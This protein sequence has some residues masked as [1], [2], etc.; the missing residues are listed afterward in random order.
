MLNAGNRVTGWQQ[1]HA[2][3]AWKR[4]NACNKCQAREDMQMVPIQ[5]QENIQPL[6]LPKSAGKLVIPLRG[7][8]QTAV[9]RGKHQTVQRREEFAK[10]KARDC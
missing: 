9:K 6:P 4:R 2:S 10:G 1:L 5:S 3:R 8:P 7:K